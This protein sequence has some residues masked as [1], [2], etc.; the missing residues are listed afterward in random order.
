LIDALGEEV[1]ER[2]VD[3]RG[4]AFVT[5]RGRQALGE[6]YVSVD[7][8]K[9]KGPEIGRQGPSVKIRP[10]CVPRNGRKA[11]VFWRRI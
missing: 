9:Q 7:A 10:D 8:T 11:E 2:M 4:M 6:A 3:R 5:D 1:A